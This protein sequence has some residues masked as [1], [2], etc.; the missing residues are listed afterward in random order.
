MSEIKL[1]EVEATELST[2]MQ[3]LLRVIEE[4]KTFVDSKKQEL[5]LS[6]IKGSFCDECKRQSDEIIMML[7]NTYSD[8]GDMGIALKQCVE[9]FLIFDE[10][11]A[12]KLKGD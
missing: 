4:T 7:D 8:F 3:E 10:E 6:I 2:T 11:Y 1:S 5:D 9:S 12:K